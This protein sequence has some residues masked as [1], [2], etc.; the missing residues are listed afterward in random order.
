MSRLYLGAK[1][2]NINLIAHQS[3]VRQILALPKQ[4]EW[5]ADQLAN[6]RSIFG[7]LFS[8][9]NFVT[10]LRAE[11]LTRVPEYLGRLF[12]TEGDI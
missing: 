7:R 12:K 6:F 9:E 1:K 4:V 8:D 11:S 2:R 3:H 10:L 5:T